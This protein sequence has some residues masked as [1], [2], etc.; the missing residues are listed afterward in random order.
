MEQAIPV[1]SANYT[2]I[3]VDGVVCLTDLGG[4]PSVTNDAE[5]V[6]GELGVVGVDLTQP[7]IYRDTEGQWD[8]L[9]VTNSQFSGFRFL[10]TTDQS[11]AVDRATLRAIAAR[12]EH[13]NVAGVFDAIEYH[14]ARAYFAAGKLVMNGPTGQ[15]A[16][17]RDHAAASAADD[18][19]RMTAHWR[20][21]CYVT[22]KH[23]EPETH[24]AAWELAHA[25]L[26]THEIRESSYDVDADAYLLDYHAAA[27]I[28]GVFEALRPPVFALLVAGYAETHEW[29]TDIVRDEHLSALQCG[30][31]NTLE[32]NKAFMRLQADPAV[33]YP[34]AVAIAVAMTGRA[35][36]WET[37]DAVLGAIRE[38]PQGEWGARWVAQEAAAAREAAASHHLGKLREAGTDETRFEEAFQTLSADAVL[39]PEDVGEIARIY[40]NDMAARYTTID[41]AL[42][43]IES[44]FY[45]G[46]AAEQ[47]A[48]H[49]QGR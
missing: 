24:R 49:G 47:T 23:R 31:A 38:A 32:F 27:E 20:T 39:H 25:Y 6:I 29:A 8:E 28:A 15:H 14:G 1:A 11:V 10:N 17:Y 3:V 7:V 33:D 43:A 35:D 37:K 21:F 18:I 16:I 22:D 34:V 48:Q 46:Q 44:K 13:P 2:Y 19:E 12:T 36:D 40:A 5:A 30:L 4:A 41:E 42:G 26:S 45:A 9:V